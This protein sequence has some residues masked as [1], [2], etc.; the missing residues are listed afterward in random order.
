MLENKFQYIF[1]ISVTR[2]FLDIC[3][4]RLSECNEV[5]DYTSRYQIEF[6]KLISPLNDDLWMLKKTIKLKLQGS[7]PRHFDKD[8]VARVLVIKTV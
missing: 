8:Y 6:D 7:L 1:P 5:V 3:S 2:I 4:V